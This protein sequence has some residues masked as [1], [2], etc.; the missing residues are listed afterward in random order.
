MEH[1]DPKEID[2]LSVDT[3]GS[4]FSILSAFDFDAYRIRVITVEHNFTPA[5]EQIRDLLESR[6]FVRKMES[7]SLVDDWYVCGPA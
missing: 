3:E 5:R 7:V 6:G 4:E 1:N 2:Y